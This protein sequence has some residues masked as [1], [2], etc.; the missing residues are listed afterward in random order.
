[1]SDKQQHLDTDRH[2]IGD[3]WHYH[4]IQ[5][6]NN[7]PLW[8][9]QYDLYPL[10]SHFGIPDDLKDKTV[11]DIGTATGFFAFECEKRGAIAT[12]SELESIEDW[13]TRGTET[14]SAKDI[15][16]QNQLDFQ[17]AKAALNSNVNMIY[18]S[19]G[20]PLHKQHGTFDWTILGALLTHI[21]DPMQALVNLRGLTNE[22]AVVISTYAENIK[23]PV[24]LWANDARPIDWWIPSKSVIPLML[25][26][27][28]FSE[29]REISDFQ[30]KHKARPPMSQ[31]CWHAIP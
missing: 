15:P 6:N 1:M 19:I 27:A 26:A 20:E 14:Y 29:V 8:H 17:R 31:A 24:L 13:D 25:K 28:G 2:E 21:S 12:G 10:W 5:N 9:G 3:D 4:T 23:E 7:Q 30:L 22:C 16:S 11:L 18:G